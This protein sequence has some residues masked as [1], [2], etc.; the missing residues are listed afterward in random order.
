[1]NRGGL[2]TMLMNYYRK[3][4]RSKVQFDFMVNRLEQGDYDNEIE[5]LGGKIYRMPSIRPGNYKKYFKKLDEFFLRNKNYKVVH[6]HINENSAFVLRAAKKA[7]IP[8]RISHSHLAG[9]PFDHK[10][11]FRMYAKFNLNKNASHYFACSQEAGQWLFGKDEKI[12]RELVIFK[13][14]ISCEEFSYDESIRFFIRKKLNLEN[15]FVIGHVGRFNP[16]KNHA[17]LIDIFYEV[18]KRNK[19]AVLLLVGEGYLEENIRKKVDKLSLT[20]SVRFLGLRGDVANIMQA[21]DLFLF[22]SLYEGLGVVLIEAQ[23]AGL[24]CIT[25]TGI[26]KEADVTDTVEFLKLKDSAERWAIKVLNSDLQRNSGIQKIKDRGY[27][28]QTNIEWLTS[29]YTRYYQKINAA[30]VM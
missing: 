21:M 12:K 11:I 24:K 30:E 7:G 25:S 22:P 10:L 27:D 29:F 23:A 5:K 14:S 3:M 20:Q 9:L 13:N 6:S 1:M 18:Y 26:P 28:V 8:C 15:K 17:F 16:Q 4:D 19:N 2:E